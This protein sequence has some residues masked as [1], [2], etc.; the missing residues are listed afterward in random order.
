[1][2]GKMQVNGK[3]IDN[4]IHK[5]KI[6]NPFIYGV[7]CLLV[8]VEWILMGFSYI[9][10]DFATYKLMYDT[11]NAIGI[12]SYTGLEIGQRWLFRLGGSFGLDYNGFLAIYSLFAIL[13]FSWGIFRLT[14]RLDI[15]LS[16]YFIFPFFYD[17][18]QIRNFFALAIVVFAFHFLEH[19]GF[20]KAVIP[21]VLVVCVAACFHSSVL[22]YLVFVFAKLK[23]SR[24]VLIISA[25]LGIIING[26]FRNKLIGTDGAIG[27]RIQVYNLTTSGHAFYGFLYLGIVLIM[28][29]IA[30]LA[31]KAVNI[32]PIKVEFARTREVQRLV[33]NSLIL[34]LPVVP[35]MVTNQVYFR[36]LRNLFVFIY[37]SVGNL[38]EL[39]FRDDHSVI[40]ILALVVAL[41]AINSYVWLVMNGNYLQLVWPVLHFNSFF[42]GKY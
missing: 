24:S 36:V 30:Y 10:N 9:N 34:V 2:V 14:K 1:M 42:G 39:R 32:G 27:G 17:V 7:A 16:L 33:L 12:N 19:D 35:L 18:T 31:F 3:T 21:Y 25:L 4:P 26:F 5:N 29:L 15:V 22:Y 37:I 13:L 11:V 6:M 8:V 20:V 38:V 41:A 40:I 28:I 23:S